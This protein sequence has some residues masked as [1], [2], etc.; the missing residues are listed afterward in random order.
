MDELYFVSEYGFSSTRFFFQAEDGVYIKIVIKSAHVLSKR[1]E[2]LFRSE[3]EFFNRFPSTLIN[4][5]HP[6]WNIQ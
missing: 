5:R 6:S 3:G 4:A 2:G 1:W